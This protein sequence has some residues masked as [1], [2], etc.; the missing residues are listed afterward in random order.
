[1]SKS[2]NPRY[3]LN[4]D[5]FDSVIDKFIKNKAYISYNHKDTNRG[6]L[7]QFY[8]KK[9]TKPISILHCYISLGRVSFHCDGKDA[10]IA[11]ECKNFLIENTKIEIHEMKSFV[12]KG[13][14]QE[15][16]DTI[17]F[18]LDKDYVLE[19]EE[20]KD[21]MLSR[22]KVKGRYGD[23]IS[24]IY[25][26]TETLMVQGRVGFAFM[27]F[28][29]IASELLKPDE[30]KKGHLK[31]YE[32]T[33]PEIINSSLRE[34]LPNV[35]TSIVERLDGIMSP[36]LVLLNSSLQLTDYSAF[37]FPVLKGSEGIL[38]EVFL[39]KEVRIGKDGFGAYFR[40]GNWISGRNSI[41]EENKRSS[42]LS[43]YKYY[44]KHRHSTFHTGVTFED[45][46][47]LNREEALEIVKECLKLI[48]NVYLN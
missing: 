36:S 2:N 41:F 19:E 23:V 24:I 47:T 43:L 20:L 21:A 40:D 39:N 44:N 38:K 29:E 28:V 3:T 16:Y 42:I 6:I 8:C 27:D 4:I 33:S 11:E 25:Y 30:V 17:I 9:S 22:Y 14:E 15:M 10:A 7:Y 45:S 46:R 34:L 12:A 18:F 13:V 37:A 35:D 26:N 5:E 48:D 1:M 31:M 32:V